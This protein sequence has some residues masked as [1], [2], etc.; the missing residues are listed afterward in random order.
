[1]RS[2]RPPGPAQPGAAKP[3]TTQTGSSELRRLQERLNRL[4]E[5]ALVGG[6]GELPEGGPAGWRP[7]FDLVETPDAFI[8]FAELPGV[9][10]EQVQL[11]SDGNS[12]EISGE[13]RPAGGARGYLRLEGSYGPFRRRLELPEPVDAARIVA[14]LRKGILEVTMPKRSAATAVPVRE[15]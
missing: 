12:V 6:A 14:R 2:R 9:Q 10:R 11:D 8:L 13:R 4:L 5:Q 1:M 15:G 7:L 3:G